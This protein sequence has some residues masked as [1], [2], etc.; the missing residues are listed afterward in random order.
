[1]PCIIN[2]YYIFWCG[3]GE[4]E[5]VRLCAL[6]GYS[7]NEKERPQIQPDGWIEKENVKRNGMKRKINT[8][9][10]EEERQQE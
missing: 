5:C 1:M 4:R 8:A 3:Y 10:N 7:R 6:P 2:T 9:Q